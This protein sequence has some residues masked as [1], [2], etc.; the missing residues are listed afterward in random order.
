VNHPEMPLEGNMARKG[1]C[2]Y[3]WILT[4]GTIILL[5]ELKLN[6]RSLNADAYSDIIA[7]CCAE[8]DGNWHDNR[9]I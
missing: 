5:V 9:L 3:T 7:Q 2:E 1:R 8:A 6:L 4:G